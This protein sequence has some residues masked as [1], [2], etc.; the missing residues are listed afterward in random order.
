LE[1][2]KSNNIWWVKYQ[3]N[4]SIPLKESWR[5]LVILKIAFTYGRFT[6]HWHYMT[7]LLTH[8]T[9]THKFSYNN[10]VLIRYLSSIL[11][12]PYY[13]FKLLVCGLLFR[14]YRLHSFYMKQML[15]WRDSFGAPY[16]TKKVV[17]KSSISK[18][19]VILNIEFTL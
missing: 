7:I 3:D 11:R 5:Q 17:K 9:H 1:D 2:L 16:W 14:K 10:Y 13:F 19:F 6:R 18:F 4:F 8:V 15:T 12:T